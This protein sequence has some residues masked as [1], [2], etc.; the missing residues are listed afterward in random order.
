MTHVHIRVRPWVAWWVCLGIVCG[1]IAVF[2]ILLRD[3]TRSQ[4]KIIL[5]VGVVQWILGG[6]MCWAFEGIQITVPAR[7]ARGS[8]SARVNT[9]Q[10]WHPASDFIL[11]GGRKSLLPTKY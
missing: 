2:N 11:P 1:V 7:P 10:E 5:L 6:L 3:L 8:E 9:S 4:E